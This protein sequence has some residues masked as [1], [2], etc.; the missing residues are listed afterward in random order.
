MKHRYAIACILLSAA[1]ARAGPVEIGRFPYSK[2]LT[3]PE[4]QG[5]K[6]GSFELDDELLNATVDGCPNFRIVDADNREMPFL[7]RDKTEARQT[8]N[9]RS[10]AAQI[11]SLQPLPGNRIELV[12]DRDK[13]SKAP[14]AA[15]L[16]TRQ[17]NYEK[18]VSIYGSNTRDEWYK[19][20]G[21]API[22]DYSK[23]VDLKNDRVDVSGP[24]YRYYKFEIANITESQ[25][26]P[27][28]RFISETRGG[29]VAKEIKH[30]AFERKDF[31]IESI[32]FVEETREV[33]E[34]KRVTRAYPITDLDVSQD[35][36]KQSTV[37]AFR[38]VRAP[39]RSLVLSSDTPNFS[40]PV[41]VEARDGDDESAKWKKVASATISRIDLPSIRRESMKIS[42]GGPR[43]YTQYRARIQNLDSPPI[44]V[45]GVEVS[46]GVREVLFFTKP[47][48]EYRAVYGAKDLGVPSY[49]IASVVR[50][51]VLADTDIYSPGPQQENP[52][53]DPA[54]PSPFAAGRTL[55]L[56]AV[57][58]MVLALT[59][60]IARAVK[61]I[62]S[63][64]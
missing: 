61:G 62:E 44:N 41:I 25:Q 8:V 56:C 47:E 57:L 1:L 60:L 9:R 14:V 48:G 17:R 29:E 39:L 13:K 2:D 21:P 59:W 24:R 43:R 28:V 7:V 11:L 19:V 49:D 50:N 63:A 22:F 12:V 32:T 33:V 46:G 23:H 3:P 45:T 16:E 10:F 36:E 38:T 54:L 55:F 64:T 58:A 15:I 6:I 18:T 4:E 26:S 51:T 27:L 30:T 53:H 37:V 5:G 52:D 20:G 42:L 35:E 31:R 40:R 34:G